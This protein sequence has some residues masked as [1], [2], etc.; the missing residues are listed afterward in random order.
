MAYRRKQIERLPRAIIKLLRAGTWPRDTHIGCNVQAEGDATAI[1]YAE[2][3]QR[4]G[5]PPADAVRAFKALASEGQDGAAI[6]NRYGYDP[7]EVRRMMT[8]ASLSPRVLNALAADKIDGATAQTFTLTDSYKQQD[9]CCGQ[10]VSPTRFGG[11]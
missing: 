1:S 8:L 7:R 9:K 6:A 10:Q 3:A 11:C 2:N 5:K 4:V